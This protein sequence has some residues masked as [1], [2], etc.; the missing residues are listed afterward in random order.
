MARS[1]QPM[2]P[3]CG[4]RHVGDDF[5]SVAETFE[6]RKQSMC[7]PSI[8]PSF[9]PAAAP[10]P[11]H[12]MISVASGDSLTSHIGRRA[13]PSPSD[14]PSD[15]AVAAPLA[16]LS[17][18]TTHHSP[19]TLPVRPVREFARLSRPPRTDLIPS[20]SQYVGTHFCCS[21]YLYPRARWLST[22]IT[23]QLFALLSTQQ[24]TGSLT[25]K[26]ESK[27]QR[28]SWLQR[29]RAQHTVGCDEA[30]A[31][32]VT[33]ASRSPRCRA[34]SHPRETWA[35]SDWPRRPARHPPE[36][37]ARLLTR[38]PPCPG[39]CR[40]M[41][42]APDSR[43]PDQPLVARMRPQLANLKPGPAADGH[44]T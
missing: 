34:V 11:A 18:R 22:R 27:G 7:H 5:V 41:P 43:Q 38:C 32:K 29:G 25:L 44:H 15:C 16:S 10:S 40:S 17:A 28:G 6:C 12:P 13:W 26:P 9:H 30:P 4:S 1:V 35:L 24:R 19:L 37:L 21:E 8:L 33:T 2:R 31:D 42:T 23:R 20:R 39:L 3:A 36:S 14:C